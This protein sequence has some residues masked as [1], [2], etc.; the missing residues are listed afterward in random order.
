M[1]L[2]IVRPVSISLQIRVGKSWLQGLR[3]FCQISATSWDDTNLTPTCCWGHSLVIACSCSKTKTKTKI[4][5]VRHALP[6]ERTKALVFVFVFVFVL[7]HEHS[8]KTN[9][10]PAYCFN[11]YQKVQFNSK[12]LKKVTF[13]CISIYFHFFEQ[14]LMHDK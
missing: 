3:S 4:W 8:Y 2:V 7:A 10:N 13:I 1:G 12:L 6:P 5:F 11:L 14:I 9:K